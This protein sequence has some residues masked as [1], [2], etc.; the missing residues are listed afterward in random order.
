MSKEIE[1]WR[2]IPQTNGWYQVSDWGRIKSVPHY[3]DNGN[4]KRLTRERILKT[5]LAGDNRS[6]QYVKLHCENSVLTIEIHRTVAE[7]FIPNP[8]KYDVVHHIDHNRQ[9]NMVENLMW[10]NKEEHN[11]LHQAD[12]TAVVK[13]KYGKI[14]YQYTLDGIFEKIYSSLHQAERDGF[15][16]KEIKKCCLGILSQHKGHKWGFKPL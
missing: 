8:N 13:Q 11:K 3:V 5:F 6:Y 15:G 10:I 7:L 16:R 12:R 4:G 1:E 9:N 14:I 2:D